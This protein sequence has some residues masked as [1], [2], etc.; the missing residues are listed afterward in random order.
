MHFHFVSVS[1]TAL[2]INLWFLFFFVTL[3]S[4]ISCFWFW[5]M[6]KFIVELMTQLSYNNRQWSSWWICF[7]FLRE[8]FLD[9]TS[10]L[11][12]FVSFIANLFS[13]DTSNN[14][15]SWIISSC[16]AVFFE[17]V[18]CLLYPLLTTIIIRMYIFWWEKFCN[19]SI[20]VIST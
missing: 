12:P 20:N 7:H 4:Q 2:Y 11:S 3:S 16:S 19:N 15:T 8:F 18:D 14:T 17:K 10:F 13:L 6:K 9:K 5:D 1:L